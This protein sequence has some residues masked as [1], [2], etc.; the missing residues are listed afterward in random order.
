MHFF[1]QRIESQP[2]PGIINCLAKL[3]RISLLLDQVLQRLSQNGTHLLRLEE[4]PLVKLG[5]VGQG[6]AGQEIAA[7][8]LKCFV[9]V[10]GIDPLLELGNI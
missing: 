9:Q 6:E 1:S 3:S 7:I 2:P 10:A 4:L 5:G 8:V